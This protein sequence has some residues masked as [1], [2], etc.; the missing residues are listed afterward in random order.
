MPVQGCTLP[1]LTTLDF[2]FLRH[3]VEVKSFVACDVM[4][5]GESLPTPGAQTLHDVSS[6]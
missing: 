4:S 1:Y 3:V 6:P 5:P 2:K